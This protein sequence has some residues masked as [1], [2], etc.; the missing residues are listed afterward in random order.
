MDLVPVSSE[1]E[2]PES[3]RLTN[4]LWKD[5]EEIDRDEVHQDVQVVSQKTPHLPSL[6][7]ETSE[8]SEESGELRWPHEELLLLTDDEREEAQVCFQDQSEEPGWTWSPLDPRS[9]LRTVNPQ[10]SWGQEQVEQDASWIPEEECQEAPS[11]CPLWD[12]TG[13]RVCRSQYVECPHL[14]PPRSFEG[15]EEETVQATAGVD[16]GAAAEAPDGRGCDRRRADHEAP[17]QEAGVQCACQ[18]YSVWEEAQ[19]TPP[20]DPSFPEGE[21]SHGSGNPCKASQ[22]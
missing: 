22:D 12:S 2:H 3:P 21:S 11:P 5:R 7:V 4:P 19:K 13:F 9:P 1:D 18:H 10:L 14:P 16:S 6:V 8:V 20:A 15:T 17:P